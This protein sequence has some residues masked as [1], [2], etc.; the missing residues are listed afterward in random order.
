MQYTAGFPSSDL[1]LINPSDWTL[2]YLQ[3]EAGRQ[4]QDIQL[5]LF[6]DYGRNLDS[7]PAL[8]AYFREYQPPVLAIWGKGDPIFIP[9]GAEAF[10]RD[11]PDAVV[12]FV[13]AGHFALQTK[14]WEIAEEILSFLGGVG[15]TKLKGL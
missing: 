12:K 4:N 5:S 11:L 8:H 7:Y 15:E 10:K 9:P 1:P 13:D 14:R 6:A 3:N 2:D